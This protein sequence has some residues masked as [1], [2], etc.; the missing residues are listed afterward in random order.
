MVKLKIFFATIGPISFIAS[1]LSFLAFIRFCSEGN[2]RLN[3]FA[4]V[5]K[6]FN[7]GNDTNGS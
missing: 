6:S 4:V 3:I 5:N 1:K 7:S 2:S